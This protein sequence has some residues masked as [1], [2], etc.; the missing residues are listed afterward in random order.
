[1]QLDYGLSVILA[2]NHTNWSVI[3]NAFNITLVNKNF[4]SKTYAQAAKLYT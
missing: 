2:L 1:L 3:Y 4:I